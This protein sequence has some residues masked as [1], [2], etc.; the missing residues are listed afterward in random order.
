MAN[1]TDELAAEMEKNLNVVEADDSKKN[2]LIALAN[3]EL[4]AELLENGD[5]VVEAGLVTDV[6]EKV[7]GV[8]D[9]Q[10]YLEKDLL[11][12][13]S[14]SPAESIEIKEPK[15]YEFWLKFFNAKDT[16]D[17]RKMF[18]E[19]MDVAEKEIKETETRIG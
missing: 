2:T 15:S 12:Y 9:Y 4:A 8:E 11:P 6:M 13:D 5:M 7:A 3:L 17:M 19:F 1:F 14:N 18:K 16:Y 10:N